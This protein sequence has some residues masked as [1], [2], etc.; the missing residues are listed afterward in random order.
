M[1]RINVKKEELENFINSLDKKSFKATYK[2]NNINI[3]NISFEYFKELFC[4][5]EFNFLEEEENIIIY[6]ILYNKISSSRNLFYSK[7]RDFIIN[8]FTEDI[9]FCPY[10]WKNPLIYFDE[11]NTNKRMFQFD[12]FFPKNVY[13]KWIINFYNLI[14]S[15]NACNHLKSDNN[16]LDII[17]KWWIIFHPYL[18]N[19]FLENRMLKNDLWRNSDIRL[20]YISE[21]SKFLKLWHKYMNSE[22]TF[23]TFNF[24]QDK[25]SKIKEERIK[26]KNF[27]KDDD[28]IK[29]Y[30]FKNY[31][32]KSEQEI[33]KYSNWKLKKDLIDNLEIKKETN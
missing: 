28:K 19:L 15:C 22:D 8:K 7:I 20:N 4:N 29:D 11:N 27:P 12:H 9:K 24:I 10:C 6:K 21:N 18:W 16:P 26:F 31:Y 23:N 32:P 13:H 17:N 5:D 25:R 33:L 2:N 3:K 14:P 30:F 1:I